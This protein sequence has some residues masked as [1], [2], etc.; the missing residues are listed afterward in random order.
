MKKLYSEANYREQTIRR[1][2]KQL[3]R[4]QSTSVPRRVLARRTSHRHQVVKLKAPENFSMVNNA[5]AMIGFFNDIQ[6]HTHR[7]R[8]VFIDV[9]EIQ[10]LT[11]DGL[12]TLLAKANDPKFS[13]RMS[14]QSN[15]PHDP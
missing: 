3:R 15:R 1:Q 2:R 6:F 14:I 13:L 9:S 4:L 5:E 10:A 11:S 8:S 12:L 7:G